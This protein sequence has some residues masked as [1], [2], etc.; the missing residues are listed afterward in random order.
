M[1]KLVKKQVDKLLETKLQQA[2]KLQ[3]EQNK[4]NRKSISMV[5]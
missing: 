4:V 3:R 5:Y 2:L 1:K